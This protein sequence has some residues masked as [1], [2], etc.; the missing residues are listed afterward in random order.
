MRAPATASRLAAPLLAWLGG[1]AVQLQEPTLQPAGLYLGLV[2]AGALALLGHDAGAAADP[3]DARLA[4]WPSSTDKATV[5]PSPM[6]CASGPTPDA[7]MALAP[8]F[9]RISPNKSPAARVDERSATNRRLM[10]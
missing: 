1:V 9:S 10:P 2:A 8:F 6:P 7:R 5:V 3:R 4:P